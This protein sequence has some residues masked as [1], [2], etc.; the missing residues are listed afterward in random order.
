MYIMLTNNHLLYIKNNKQLNP[1]YTGNSF[2]MGTLANSEFRFLRSAV[3]QL[4]K[5]KTGDLRVAGSSLTLAESL[6]YV[7]LQDTLSAAKYWHFQ[8]KT[9]PP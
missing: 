4:V 3:A 5:L 2:K 6:C 8:G 1:L 9:I 7:L